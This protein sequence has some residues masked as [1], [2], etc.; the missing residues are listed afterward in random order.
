MVSGHPVDERALHVGP[1]FSGP[2]ALTEW[3][4][5]EVR[6]PRYSYRRHLW[7]LA[8]DMRARGFLRVSRAMSLKTI[9]HPNG[10]VDS[11]PIGQL[12]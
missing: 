9:G 6:V 10:R 4:R 11:L 1:T 7:R 12:A 3:F 2:L 8:A 5:M